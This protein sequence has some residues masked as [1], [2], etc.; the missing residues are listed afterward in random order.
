MNSAVSSLLTCPHCG[1]A[2]QEQM[3][4]DACL[5]FHECINCHVVLRP[6][7]GDCCVFCS[8]GSVKCPP[9][10]LQADADAACGCSPAER[11]G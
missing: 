1:N 11:A 7:P 2:T 6:L 4:T 3:P 5:F 9:V 8:F 10:Q